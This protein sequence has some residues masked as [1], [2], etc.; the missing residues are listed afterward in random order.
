MPGP[1]RA[2]LRFDRFAVHPGSSGWQGLCAILTSPAERC[3]L[4]ICMKEGVVWT[5]RR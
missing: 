1:G 5:R 3:M 2:R 4:A